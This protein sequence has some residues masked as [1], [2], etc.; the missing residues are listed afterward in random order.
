[1][2]VLAIQVCNLFTSKQL[3]NEKLKDYSM[4]IMQ[5]VVYG[6]PLLAITTAEALPIMPR[7]KI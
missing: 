5:N 6:R 7:G 3:S 2:R 4:G 1:M